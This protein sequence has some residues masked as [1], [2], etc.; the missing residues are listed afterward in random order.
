MVRATWAIGLLATTLF[1]VPAMA[2]EGKAAAVKAAGFCA[3]QDS[4]ACQDA[5]TP[6]QVLSHL[7][8]GNQRFVSGARVNH[9]FK[10]QIKATAHGQFPLASVV[11]CIDSRV[12]A[13]IVF[14]QGIGDLFS[15]RVAGNIVNDDIL[16]SLEYASQ[17]AG[18][19]LIVVLGHNSCGAVKG[20]CDA[21]KLGHL[22]QLLDKITPAVSAIEE[23]GDRSSKNY[24]FVEKVAQRN[25][26]DTVKR[27]REQSAGLRE[28]EQS[29]ALMIKGALYD[30]ETGKVTW[31]N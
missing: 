10:K 1:S 22:T 3:I 9:R 15:A 18:S 23:T 17:V 11:S 28:L 6:A 30:V 20:A 12:P 21:V 29:G 7:I 19:K 2:A 5:V 24:A 8:E 31:L 14:D 27:I 16:G 4:K 26:E 13:E 25:V